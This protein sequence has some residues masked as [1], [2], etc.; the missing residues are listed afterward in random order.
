MPKL[1][2]QAGPITQDSCGGRKNCAI[3]TRG[4][5]AVFPVKI[6]RLGTTRPGRETKPAISRYF[7]SLLIASDLGYAFSTIV[8]PKGNIPVNTLAGV[9]REVAARNRGSVPPACMLN[10]PAAVETTAST[11]EGSNGTQSAPGNPMRDIGDK[12]VSFH[13][14]FAISGSPPCDG[15]AD[16]GSNRIRGIKP[17][18]KS[19]SKR[20]WDVALDGLG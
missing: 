7:P 5:P 18:L 13:T 4:P 10:V 9:P 12:T 16:A 11:T 3:A 8:G 2:L 19:C 17:E 6:S 15:N 1:D 20:S 14:S